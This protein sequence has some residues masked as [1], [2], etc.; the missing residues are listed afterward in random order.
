MYVC[1]NETT[2]YKCSAPTERRVPI[3][4]VDAS[5]HQWV[6][7]FT[8][9]DAI[10]AARVDDLLSDEFYFYDEESGNTAHYSDYTR[11][12]NVAIHYGSDLVCT[13]T[14]QL[15]KEVSS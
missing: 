4:S 13:V 6:I 14:I 2:K 9:H 8:I 7:D 3:P 15:A 10:D 12:N 1:K 5:K 11:I